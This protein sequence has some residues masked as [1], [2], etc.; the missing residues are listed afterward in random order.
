MFYIAGIGIS[1]LFCS[2]DLDL[3][4]MTFVCELDPYWRYTCA[5]YAN[6]NFLRQGFQ[7]LSS[8]RQTDTTEII[9]HAASRVV[10]NAKY[11]SFRVTKCQ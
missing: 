9:Y 3:D 4:P 7:K 8:N 1:S 5:G 11:D 2:C 6:M 10:K